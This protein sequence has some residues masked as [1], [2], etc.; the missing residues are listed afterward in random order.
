[1]TQTGSKVDYT[2]LATSGKIS[3]QLTVVDNDAE[4]NVATGE[5]VIPNTCVPICD[6]ACQ[7]AK[8]ELQRD[9][10]IQLPIKFKQVTIPSQVSAGNY[11]RTYIVVTNELISSKGSLEDLTLTVSVQGLG[12]SRQANFDLDPKE[13][14]DF[15][16]YLPISSNANGYFPIKITVSNDKAKREIYRSI[17]VN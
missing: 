12:V 17:I 8:L 1:L 9:A 6:E 7:L 2:T 5:F 15:S 10:Q 14:K 3:F 4:S 13:S 16:F 11:V